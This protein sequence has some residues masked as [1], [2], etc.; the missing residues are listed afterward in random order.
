M[1]Y[2]GYSLKYK[3][4]VENSLEMP[5][6]FNQQLLQSIEQEFNEICAKIVAIKFYMNL[7]TAE[8]PIEL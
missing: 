4:E 5:I 8:C 6:A 7:C 3:Q 2:S 1:Q